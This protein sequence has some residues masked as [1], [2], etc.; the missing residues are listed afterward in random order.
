[1]DLI[2]ILDFVDEYIWYIAF[3]LIICVGLFATVA[4]RGL[5]VTSLGEMA[6]NTFKRDKAS[7][8]NKLSSFQVFCMSMGSRIGVGNITGPIMA[9][10]VGG[11]GAI[12]WMWVFAGIGMA[13]EVPRTPCSTDSA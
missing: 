5:Q 3:V 13:T 11:P 4:L 10:L 12:L 2:G 1:M 6:R 9:L 8:E 7:S